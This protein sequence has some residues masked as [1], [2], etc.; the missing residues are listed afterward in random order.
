MNDN[1]IVDGIGEL[2]R[3]MYLDTLLLGIKD[4]EDITL[5]DIKY[6]Y[7]NLYDKNIINNKIYSFNQ[8]V[9]LI[10]NNIGENPENISNMIENLMSLVNSYLTPSNTEK[11]MLGEVFTSLDLVEDM[12]NK[13]PKEVWSNP[14]L[15]WL[16]PANGIGNFPVIIV[17]KLMIGLEEWQPDSELRLKH[18][19]ENMIYVCELQSKNMFIYLQLFDSENK[20]KMNFHRG[21][22]LEDNF[23][24]V[25]KDWGVDKFDIIVGNPPYQDSPKSDI[26]KTSGSVLWDKFVYKSIDLIKYSGYLTLVHP[27][28]WRKPI[29]S[30]SKI[31]NILD[32]FKNY[33]LMYLEIHDIKD[34]LKTFN[35]GTRYDF[36]CFQKNT[37]YNSTTIKDEEGNITNVDIRTMRFIPNK[38]IND[39][40]SLIDDN[41]SISVIF[42]SSYH[43]SRDYVSD[44]KDTNHIYEVIHSTPKTGPRILYSSI[45]DKGHFGIPKII[46]GES[47]INDVIIDMD[48]KY[49]MTQGSIGIIL[50]KDDDPIMIKKVLESDVFKNILSSCMWSNFR[51]DAKLFMLFKKKWYK[52]I[53]KNYVNK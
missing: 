1:T 31:I 32:I 25:M 7:D 53:D 45:N 41:D 26:S 18:I 5:E 8:S 17:K 23:S 14:N 12:L 50:E 48:G 6:I 20:Y 35:A 19:L 38:N 15:K 51:I 21:S 52:I 3:R 46:F 44:I 9:N 33:N 34:G 4:S 28:I 29:N 49:G 27:S 39:V 40:L 47:G 2:E 16:D 22:F 36:Y 13:L 43:A 11:K 37:E 24:E 10:Y 30:K 42:D